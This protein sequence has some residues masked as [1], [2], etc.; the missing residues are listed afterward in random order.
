MFK[1]KIS[2]F[3]FI[4]ILAL[5]MS[6]SAYAIDAMLPALG[7]IGL[8]FNLLKSND[9]QLIISFLFLGLS[10]GQV[11]YGPLSDS[12]GRRRA[13]FFGLFVFVIGSLFCIYSKTMAFMLLGRVLQGFGAA[14]SRIITMALVRD[15]F[16]GNAMARIM[17]FVTAIF[18]IVPAL[19]PAVGQLILKYSDWR[20]VFR[21]Q[22]ILGLIAVTWFALR[23]EETLPV[24]KR[25]KFNLRQLY[26]ATRFTLNNRNTMLYALASGFVFAA[27]MGYLNSAQQV[28]QGYFSLG[29]R[30]PLF[31]GIL[32]IAIG[33]ASIL[34]SQLVLKYGMQKLV[35]IAAVTFTIMSVN[36]LLWLLFIPQWINLIT[37]MGTMIVVFFC[38]GILFGNLSSLALEPMGE[39]AG[40]ASAVIGTLQSIISVAIGLVIGQMYDGTLMPLILGFASMGIATVI[41]LYLTRADQILK[42]PG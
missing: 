39:I 8:E 9:A 36:Y 34:N 24:H 11:F 33:G 19:A 40:S 6:I 41:S 12:I 35:A 18:I 42:S 26:L 1:S 15:K 16:S 30:L 5:L 20:M 14:G 27:F 17:S 7:I 3:E 2:E 22:L 10:L 29:D 37:F 4:A 21:S 25:K 23:M 32:S 13:I 38:A 28:Y 31:F